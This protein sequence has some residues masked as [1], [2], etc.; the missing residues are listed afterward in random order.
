MTLFSTGLNFNTH[1]ANLNYFK[2]LNEVVLRLVDQGRRED[3]DEKIMKPLRIIILN[4]IRDA[5]EFGKALYDLFTA[6][7][8]TDFAWSKV[9]HLLYTIYTK[10][11]QSVEGAKIFLPKE[12][13]VVKNNTPWKN[14]GTK[15]DSQPPKRQR[16][17]V[18]PKDQGKP[19]MPMKP[20]TPKGSS[21]ILCYGC[22]RAGHNSKECIYNGKK[23]ILCIRILIF[24]A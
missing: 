14:K 1:E 11:I 24:R 4:Q 17:D 13:F 12:W 16:V 10:A 20:V 18:K 15:D 2:E 7:T 6:R 21:T 23:D 5:T 19:A 9:F 22:G 8:I 3:Q